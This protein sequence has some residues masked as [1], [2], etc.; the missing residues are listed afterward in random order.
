MPDPLPRPPFRAPRAWRRFRRRPL[1]FWLLA[2]GLAALTAVTVARSVGGAR[3]E[4]DAYGPRRAALVAAV[5]LGAGTL[6]GPDDVEVRLLPA[7]LLPAGALAA[8]DAATG[9]T[10]TAGILAGEAVTTARLGPQGLSPVASL[11]PPGTR[12]LAVPTGPGALPLEMGDTVDVLATLDL[13]GDGPPT[14]AVAVAALVVHVTEEA[15]TV[16]VSI[17]EAPRVAYALSAGTVTLALSAR[18]T[19]PAG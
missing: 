10:V 14:G 1:P 4:L 5:D 3:A 9:R 11:L 19:P 2:A 15:V 7:N 8:D 6:V 16:A 12:G 13:G 17:E 18:A